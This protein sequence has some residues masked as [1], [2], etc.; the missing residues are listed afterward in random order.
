MTPPTRHVHSVIG[1]RVSLRDTCRAQS[2]ARVLQH[3][4]LRVVL[5]MPD[6]DQTRDLGG[7]VHT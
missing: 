4:A 7:H 1:E 2:L 5:G 6:Q 3:A